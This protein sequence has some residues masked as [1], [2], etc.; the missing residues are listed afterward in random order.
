MPDDKQSLETTPLI[1][2][3]PFCGEQ[4]DVLRW[5][6]GPASKRLIACANDWCDAQPQVS[7]PTLHKA[8]ER[9]NRRAPIEAPTD[10]AQTIDP[11]HVLHVG[12][13]EWARRYGTVFGKNGNG[14]EVLLLNTVR[15]LHALPAMRAYAM[16]CHRTNPQLA[17]AIGDILLTRTTESDTR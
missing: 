10:E 1:L 17:T 13:A 15:D 14:E 5:H 16:S 11:S 12:K 2:G 8:L 7:G 3:C 6:G 4:P 9:W